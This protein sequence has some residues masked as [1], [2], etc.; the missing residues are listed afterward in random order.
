MK[1]MLLVVLTVLA[2]AT[3]ANAALTAKIS[4]YGVVDPP[5][6]T[7]NLQVS[8]TAVIDIHSTQTAITYLLI[9]GPGSISKGPNF[10]AWEQSSVTI[11]SSDKPDLLPILEEMGYVDITEFIG[12]DI[13]D[14]SDPYTQPSGKVIDGLVFHCERLGDVTLTLF[15]V[16]LG[17]LD[18]Q[19]I[20]Q[21]PEPITMVLLGLGGLFLRR[22]K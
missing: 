11:P 22:R 5:D 21:I 19:V 16:D 15:D 1:K 9:Q 20:H 12:I 14:T 4:V 8:D 17:V 3:V 7:I 18:S 2:M 6:T 13:L 10:W